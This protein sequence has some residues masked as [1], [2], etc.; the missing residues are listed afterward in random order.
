[1]RKC[2]FIKKFAKRKQNKNGVE[3]SNNSRHGY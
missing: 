3:E 2:R 1:M